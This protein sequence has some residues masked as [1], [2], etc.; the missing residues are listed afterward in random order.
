[1]YIKIIN[2]YNK[3]NSKFS[4]SGSC[5]RTVNYLKG[6]AK[7][8]NQECIFFNSENDNISPDDVK[9][10]IDSNT[11][12]IAKEDEKFFSLAISPSAEELEAIGKDKEKLKEYVKDVMKIYAENFNIKG[13]QLSQDNLLYFATLHEER[14]YKSKDYKVK[15]KEEKAG[16]K[17]SGDNTH[18]HVIVSARDKQMKTTLN[19][20]KSRRRFSIDSFS[21]KSSIQFADKFN[22]KKTL[23]DYYSY[24]N[25][26]INSNIE[27]KLYYLNEKYAINLDS[28][29]YTK[30]LK[31][32]DNKRK[33]FNNLITLNKELKSGKTFDQCSN[34]NKNL[35][36]KVMIIKEG[37]RIEQPTLDSTLNDINNKISSSALNF[38]QNMEFDPTLTNSIVPKKKK[39]K[40]DRGLRK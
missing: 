17:K 5:G 18:I 30:N 11:K 29:Y 24:C 3:P 2:T 9:E 37:Q 12:G 27:N 6:E 19:P 1:M 35:E 4:N 15:N 32:I 40:I 13:K 31:D 20:L 21:E 22:H 25:Y 26:K 28:K 38:L 10:Q 23:E 36:F 16:N 33:F 34:I 7:E 39:K 14:K 8:K